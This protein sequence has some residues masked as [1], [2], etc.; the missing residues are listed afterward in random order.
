MSPLWVGFK[1]LQAHQ[2]GSGGS[3]WQQQSWHPPTRPGSGAG[4]VVG[5]H[6]NR[7]PA[8]LIGGKRDGVRFGDEIAVGRD[9]HDSDVLP[10]ARTHNDGRIG[11]S[12]ECEQPSQVSGR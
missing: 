2:F 4:N 1:S 8:D 6:V 12:I 7:V 5:I 11:G 10:N 3:L 9:R